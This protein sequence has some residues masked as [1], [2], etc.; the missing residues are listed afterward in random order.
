MQR[1]A[2]GT[3]EESEEVKWSPHGLKP[4]G[5]PQVLATDYFE[6][7]IFLPFFHLN[8]TNWSFGAEHTGQ[9][10]GQAPSDT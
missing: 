5:A 2:S 1:T 6:E 3:R 10:L 9:T 4:V 8:S 7:M